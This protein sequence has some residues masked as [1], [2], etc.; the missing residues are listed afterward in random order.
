[1]Y[2]VKAYQWML[3]IQYLQNQITRNERHLQKQISQLDKEI[4][5]LRAHLVEV[6]KN[7]A[8]YTRA[9]TLPERAALI[10]ALQRINVHIEQEQS[11]DKPGV[12]SYE[13]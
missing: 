9:H 5:H 7:F 2:C 11:R 13:E 3:N 12:V 8:L 6:T 4:Y 10:E 1:M